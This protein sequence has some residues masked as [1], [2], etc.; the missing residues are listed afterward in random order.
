MALR[1][2]VAGKNGPC[3]F[4]IPLWQRCSKEI[5]K[6]QQQQWQQSEMKE[7]LQLLLAFCQCTMLS[8][9]FSRSRFLFSISILHLP[10]Y[11]CTLFCRLLSTNSMK[12]CNVRGV[13]VYTKRE[14][15][16]GRNVT[17]CIMRHRSSHNR[18][19]YFPQKH[20]AMHDDMLRTQTY[21]PISCF[22]S[23]K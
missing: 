23:R 11:G 14:G 7:L 5:Q 9:G 19:Q 4:F 1:D 21:L 10:F 12:W 16:R 8:F 18:K 3:F 6:E 13:R 22:Q 2:I 20:E 15:W 17:T